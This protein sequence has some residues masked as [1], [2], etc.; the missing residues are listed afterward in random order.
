M[1]N[2]YFKISAALFLSHSSVNLTENMCFKASLMR[3]SQCT[4]KSIPLEIGTHL[5]KWFEA[6]ME[7]PEMTPAGEE[8]PLAHHH[9]EQETHTLPQTDVVRN[10][11]VQ[12]SARLRRK[13]SIV[14]IDQLTF[15]RDL[16][17]AQTVLLSSPFL[18]VLRWVQLVREPSSSSHPQVTS[19][20]LS[21]LNSIHSHPI[22]LVSPFC[23]SSSKLCTRWRRPWDN[24]L[25]I[26][27]Q[28]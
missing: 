1:V 9:H 20:P 21:V 26:W 12:S 22:P 11:R 16:L 8:N 6:E 28:M 3:V 14:S 10:A 13:G 15:H 4:F 19:F 5:R 23:L 17:G 25:C 24:P 27:L 7:Y 2:S 18:L